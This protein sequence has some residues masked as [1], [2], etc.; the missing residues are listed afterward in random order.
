MRE[1]RRGRREKAGATIPQ[2]PWEVVRNPYPPMQILSADQMQDLHDTS[3]RI[4]KELGVKVMGAN[5]RALF[6]RA[7]ILSWGAR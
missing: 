1:A 4:L 3:I 7:S 5:A 6:A 2:L